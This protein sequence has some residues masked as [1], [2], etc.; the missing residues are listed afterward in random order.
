[1]PVGRTE[2]ANG[3]LP[4][5]FPEGWYFVASR[6]SLERTKLIQ[7]T[8]MGEN[9]VVW[10]DESGNVCVAE[11]YC[12]HLGSNLGPAAGGCV[13]D[14]RLIWPFHGFEYNA[15]GYCVDTPYAPA[16]A[17]MRLRVF[18]TAEMVGLIFAWWGIGGRAPQWSLP[19]ETP[20]QTGWSGTRIWTHRFPG[21]PQ[22]TTENAVDM[23]HLRYVHGYDSVG[24]NETIKIDGPRFENSFDFATTRRI[25]G[26]PLVSLNLTAQA[27]IFGLGYSYVDVREHS[28]GFDIRL[29]IMAT[30]VDGTDIDMSVASQ[31]REIRS[32]KRWL[33]GLG[34]LP[35]RLR[36]PIMNR[37]ALYF[38]S[39]DVLQDVTIWSRKKS[40]LKPLLS[41]SD[42]EIMAYR[43]YCA[44]F[45]PET[46]VTVGDG[47][48]SAANRRPTAMEPTPEQPTTPQP[49]PEQPTAMEPAP[50]QPTAMEPA[51]QPTTI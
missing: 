15:D 20:D 37:I 3:A 33:P 4:S 25:A 34:F 47:H 43:A 26:V 32:P 8:W 24:R 22:E 13:R 48:R 36:A 12:P 42:G 17:D 35:R 28:I 27:S 14:G 38:Q 51:T 21:H 31:V 9:I 23:A 11:A 7:K 46:P 39:R 49:T 18:E 19:A 41:R 29:W 30:P 45:Y 44:Q 1:M 16:P 5:P 50:A 2:E 6:Q 40:R 10:A